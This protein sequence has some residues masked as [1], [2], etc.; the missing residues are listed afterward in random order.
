MS[1]GRIRAITGALAPSAVLL[2]IA[3]LG[4]FFDTYWQYVFAISITAAVI[5][6]ALAMLVGY[7]RCITIATGAMLAIGAYG[8]TIPVRAWKHAVSGGCCDRHPAGCM[9]RLDAGCSRGA[10]SQPQSRDGHARVSGGGDHRAARKQDPDR[11]RG[12]HACTA[13]AHFRHLVRRAMQISCCSA[14]RCMRWPLLPMTVLLAGPFG[15]NLR[16]RCLQRER[17]A[18]V[19]H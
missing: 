9:R 16:A 11:R 19:R 13:A 10:V 8:A 4:L 7:A 1:S 5:G 14:P 3:I 18:R 15:K 6:S 2:A 12:R 17:R